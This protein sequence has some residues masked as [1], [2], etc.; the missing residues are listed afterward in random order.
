MQQ[1]SKVTIAGAG[2]GNVYRCRN[3]G[4]G[5]AEAPGAPAPPPPP[6]IILRLHICCENTF[7]FIALFI[8]Y[9]PKNYS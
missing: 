7:W 5:G 4:G 1:N 3:G 6:P 8:L 2:H 9:V